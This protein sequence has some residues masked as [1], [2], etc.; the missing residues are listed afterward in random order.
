MSYMPK[1]REHS[2]KNLILELSNELDMITIQDKYNELSYLDVIQALN[3][4]MSGSF[5]W[6]RKTQPYRKLKEQTKNQ[7]AEE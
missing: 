4:T 2:R 5:K 1:K 7:E 3:I 6:L